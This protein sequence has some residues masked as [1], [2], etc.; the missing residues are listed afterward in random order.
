MIKLVK[1]VRKDL[2]IDTEVCGWKDSAFKKHKGSCSTFIETGT[3]TGFGILNAVACDFKEMYFVE[4][5]RSNY[6]DAKA[7][8]GHIPGVHIFL[9]QS[10]V[11][12]RDSILPNIDK[13]AFFWLDAHPPGGS[14]FSDP[15]KK[16]LEAIKDHHIKSHTIL[17]DDTSFMNKE[18]LIRLL[19][20]INESYTI[21][22]EPTPHSETEI[23]VA[24]L[25]N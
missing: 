24:K 16:E 7:R 10:D 12:L 11:A 19:K 25:G 14:N 22:Y 20:G 5:S 9:G 8:C 3:N 15:I 18:E 1:L 2:N 23:L 13:P 17:I 4:I 21:S 6:N